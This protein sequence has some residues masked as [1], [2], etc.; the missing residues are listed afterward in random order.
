MFNLYVPVHFLEKKECWQT[1]R[2]FV[3]SNS[4]TNIIVAGDLNL[5][6]DPKERRG[7]IN[8]RDQMLLLVEDLI[9]QWD[10]LDFKPKKGLYT[11]T[12]N[13]TGASHISA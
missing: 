5:V 8:S 13:R 4:P 9:Q 10:I 3:E 2:D 7:G 6:F 12:N 11:W 1:L